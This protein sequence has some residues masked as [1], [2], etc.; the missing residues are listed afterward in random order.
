MRCGAAIL[1]TGRR[2]QTLSRIS[3]GCPTTRSRIGCCRPTAPPA[4]ASI[5]A[6]RPSPGRPSER[7]TARSQQSPAPATWRS[8]PAMF[9]TSTETT[10]P[11][12]WRPTAGERRLIR[13]R[14]RPFICD[15]QLYPHVHVP[16]A[17]R[18]GGTSARIA[19]V[20]ALAS[21]SQPAQRRVALVC[22]DVVDFQ[23]GES[24][25]ASS[26]LETLLQELIVAIWIYLDW[27]NRHW[28]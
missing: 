10:A 20:A 16:N 4:Y 19:M 18:P 2:R 9:G 24:R 1:A 7:R 27:C 11:S 17:A 3:R 6:M 26:H 14:F 12:Q 13:P 15:T 22:M 21:D 23:N 5:A 8:R 28:F 25:D